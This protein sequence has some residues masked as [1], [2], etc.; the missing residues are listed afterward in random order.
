MFL[1]NSRTL[2]VIAPCNRLHKKTT[3]GTTYAEGTWLICRIPSIRLFLHT[4]GFTPR[5]TCAGSGYEYSESLH[6]PFSRLQGINLILLK[7]YY[8]KLTRILII[9]IL[10]RL[11]IIN[12]YD[13]RCR[14]SPKGQKLDLCCH[15][16]LNN[17]GI[18]TCLPFPL[19]QLG[20]WLG[21]T[22]P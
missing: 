15:I 21:S 9:T 6:V 7:K 22:N 5:G 17:T 2:L 10:L 1:L 12:I 4:L 14:S 13:S 3:A 11:N 20:D 8:S 19:L 16:Y 18:L